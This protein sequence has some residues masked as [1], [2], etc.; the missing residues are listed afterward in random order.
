MAAVDV[1]RRDL[2]TVQAGDWET[3]F[4]LSAGDPPAG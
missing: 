2:Q 4:G 3:A 1:M